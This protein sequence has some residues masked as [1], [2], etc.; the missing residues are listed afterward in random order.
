MRAVDLMP[1]VLEKARRRLRVLRD[2]RC[3]RKRINQDHGFLS[4]T[5]RAIGVEL[6]HP[7]DA[8]RPRT[9]AECPPVLEDGTRPC[10]WVSCRYHLYLDV[11]PDSGSLILNHPDKD[12]DEL[13]HSC[14]LDEAERLGAAG[15]DA[16]LREIGDAIGTTR[17]GARQA[18]E[19]ALA[20]YREK[21]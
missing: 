8:V 20:S 4:D 16:L 12:P 11:D 14:A 21:R 10:P 6:Q 17:E 5:E 13:D 18:I 1:P 9:R 19:A 3:E 15:E 7:P 2:G